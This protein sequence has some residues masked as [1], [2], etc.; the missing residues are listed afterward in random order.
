[1]PL[2]SKALEDSYNYFTLYIQ[3]RSTSDEFCTI[4]WDSSYRSLSIRKARIHLMWKRLRTHYLTQWSS[5]KS[6]HSP[7]GTRRHLTGC[8]KLKFFPELRCWSARNKLNQLINR[9]EP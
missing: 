4:E 1:M 6:V 9:S 2:L 3:I 8:V 5:T 7:R